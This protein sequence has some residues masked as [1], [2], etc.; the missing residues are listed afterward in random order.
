MVA[1]NACSGHKYLA[2][3]AARNYNV[4]VKLS[5]RLWASLIDRGANGGIAGTDTRVIQDTGRTIDLSGIDNH[6]INNL[7]I[8]KAGGVVRS[9]KGEI[10]LVMNEYAHMPN[11]KSIHSC[12][13][14][15]H[16]KTSVYEKSPKV[17][18][19]TPCLMTIEG[20][21]IPISIISGLAYIKMRPY[22]DDEFEKLP[23]V[24]ISSP[25]IWDPKVLDYS[26]EEEW[27]GNQQCTPDYFKDS[28]FD[29]YG[30]P[31]PELIL[32]NEDEAEDPQ[33]AMNDSEAE[34]VAVS[35]HNI[36]A[37]LHQI[38]K[39]ETVSSF[40]VYH[41]D[42]RLVDVNA[43]NRR[44]SKRIANIPK[45]PAPKKRSPRVESVKRKRDRKVRFE[46]D[47]QVST[48]QPD[49]KEDLRMGRR[50]LEETPAGLHDPETEGP[51]QQQPS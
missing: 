20:H 15:E 23:H 43:S 51:L 19:K 33:N 47:K 24:V 38:I 11:A 29:Q 14:L 35:Q 8:V 34:G 6:T 3:S 42:H 18:G 16:Y 30:Q 40:Y 1:S 10:I 45:K 44:R 13:Q 2:Y 50:Y 27:Y 39:D 4:S 41:M 9:N 36:K 7:R 28:M 22:T 46:E 31:V 32:P 48:V 49:E 25:N 12:G 26:V 37:H 21:V 17:T 5:S